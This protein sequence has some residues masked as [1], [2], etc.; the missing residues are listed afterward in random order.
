LPFY[1][2]VLKNQTENV[3][4]FIT[5]ALASQKAQRSQPQTKFYS[6]S[7]SRFWWRYIFSQIARGFDEAVL[8]R[9]HDACLLSHV[10]PVGRA[11]WNADTAKLIYQAFWL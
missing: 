2:A 10:R 5:Q 3:Q 11:F 4:S 8:P 6:Q 9:K 1:A 7:E